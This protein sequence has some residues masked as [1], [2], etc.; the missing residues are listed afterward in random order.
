MY[1]NDERIAEIFVNDQLEI[2]KGFAKNKDLHTYTC[3]TEYDLK[4]NV[5]I[6]YRGVTCGSDINMVRE[7]NILSFKTNSKIKYSSNHTEKQNKQMVTVTI[8]MVKEHY[9]N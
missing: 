8:W 3:K 9:F 2:S 4:I 5:V 6:A 7:K 1:D